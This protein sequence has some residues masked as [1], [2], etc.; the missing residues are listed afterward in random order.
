MSGQT[1]PVP[2]GGPSITIRRTK[3]EDAPVCGRVCFDAFYKISTSHGFPCEFPSSEVAVGILSMMF[4]HPACYCVAADYDLARWRRSCLTD[5]VTQLWVVAT[6]RKIS[7]AEHRWLSAPI[8]K[9]RRIGHDF[10]I[11]FA[12]EKGRP[13]C[14]LASQAQFAQVSWLLGRCFIVGAYSVSARPVN[15]FKAE[16]DRR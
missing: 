5:W 12:E 14:V 4:S 10:F 6:G 7:L 9:T 2:P 16:R 13:C 3:P 8:G 11:R 15:R 1:L